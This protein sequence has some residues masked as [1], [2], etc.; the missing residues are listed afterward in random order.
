MCLVVSPEVS[1]ASSGIQNCFVLLLHSILR[2]SIFPWIHVTYM[3]N[4]DVPGFHTGSA[5]G[6]ATHTIS[7]VCLMNP[8]MEETLH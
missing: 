7:F 5:M 4:K 8:V 1:R 2:A 3:E 6:F